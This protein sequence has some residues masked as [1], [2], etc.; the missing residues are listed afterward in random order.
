MEGSSRREDGAVWIEGLIRDFVKSGANNLANG[1]GE[2]AWADPLV[3]YSSG[4]DPLYEEIKAHIGPF[5]WTPQ[6]IFAK[7][8]LSPQ[9]DPRELTVI[10]WVLPQT[11]A[12]KRDNRRETKFPSERWARA[13]IFGGQANDA[14]HAHLA[15]AMNQ[16]GFPAVA[17]HLSPLWEMKISDRY[18]IASTWSQRHAAYVSGLGTFGLCDG[19]ITRAGKAIVCGSLVA[20]IDVPPSARPYTDRHGYCLFF[21][22]GTCRKCM[23]RCPAGAITEAGHDKNK[24]LAYLQPG[25]AQYV[26]TQFGF[27]GYGCG[28][29]Q[30]GVP[31]ESR[32]PLSRRINPEK[33]D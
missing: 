15:D 22:E 7:T 30:T 17:P 6:E 25:T 26:K 12:T 19:L 13:R 8:F 20:R 33:G 31:C 32:I 9:T 29:C 1:T 4:S 23:E 24:C 3:G 16:A 11:A 28:F 10:S 18:G 27:D 2:P 21:S 5:Y 14:L